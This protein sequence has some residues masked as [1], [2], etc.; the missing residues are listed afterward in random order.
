VAGQEDQ[1]GGGA[2]RPQSMG[3][4]GCRQGTLFRWLHDV[5]AG[6][7]FGAKPRWDELELVGEKAA[8]QSYVGE[9]VP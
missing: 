6:V 2:Q 3:G 1:L 8:S 9:V 4:A 7:V 5:K